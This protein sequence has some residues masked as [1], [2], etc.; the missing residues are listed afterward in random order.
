VEKQGAD[1]VTRFNA[2]DISG[3]SASGS[4]AATLMLD[5]APYTVVEGFLQVV[6][7]LAST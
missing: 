1:P 3:I 5:K 2:F 4:D 6:K 7:P